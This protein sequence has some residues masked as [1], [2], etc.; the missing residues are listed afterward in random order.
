MSGY[1]EVMHRQPHDVRIGHAER[2]RAATLLGEHFA[3]GRL[4]MAEFDERIQRVYAAR[5][6]G[7]LEPLFADLPDTRPA[8]RPQ[9]ATTRRQFEV[10]RIG[11]IIAVLL[12]CVA[13][14]A[15]LRIPPFFVFPLFWIVAM[16][17]GRR[18]AH[19]RRY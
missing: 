5:T 3:A 10:A 6:A 1:G 11:L 16:S 7:E 19:H 15:L 2:E 17:R 12:A 4:D 18:W 8:A 14:I 9:T 13:W